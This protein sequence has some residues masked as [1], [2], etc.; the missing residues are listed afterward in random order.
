MF[1]A[2]DILDR[3]LER[4][5]V[6]IRFITSSG[7]A[8]EVTHPDLVMLGRRSIVIGVASTEYPTRFATANRVAIMH[9]TD[10]QEIPRTPSGES[11][12]AG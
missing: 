8:Y 12:G 6:S 4:P 11:N 9:L 10:M 3:L 7:Q 2:A 5:F 1:T